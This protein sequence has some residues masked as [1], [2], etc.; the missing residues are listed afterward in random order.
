MLVPDVVHDD[1]ELRIV[2]WSAVVACR[3][4]AAPTKEKIE[5]VGRHQRA[6]AQSTVDNRIVM[7]TVFAPNTGALV[8]ATAREAATGLA[9]DGREILMGLAQV[10]EGQGFG[11]AAARAVMSG[12]QLA[13]RAGYPT[14]VFGSTDEALPWVSELLRKAGLERDADDVVDALRDVTSS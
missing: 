5:L 4:K 9:R 14:K 12:I 13:V 3:W 6:L 8:S 2:T 10:V 1:D 7:L 11:A